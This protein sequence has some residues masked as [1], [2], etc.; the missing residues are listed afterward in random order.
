MRDIGKNIRSARTKK[1]ITQDELAEKLYVTRQTVSN[2]ENGKSR[3]DVEMLMSISEVLGVE[4]NVLLY[5]EEKTPEQKRAKKQLIISVCILVA[6]GVLMLI[7]YPLFKELVVTKYIVLP[8]LILRLAVLPLFLCLLG[9]A[10]M[11][12]CNVLLGLKKP[13]FKFRKQIFA[14]LLIFIAVIALLVFSVL[15]SA[16]TVDSF[17]TFILLNKIAMRAFTLVG[18]LPYI[19]VPIG[20]ALWLMR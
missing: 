13:D 4:L 17:H 8:L 5:G 9:F 16:F 6:I 11:Q 14:A 12:A 19:F 7:L 15:L 3:P 1:N 2:Y 10:I 18:K 20:A